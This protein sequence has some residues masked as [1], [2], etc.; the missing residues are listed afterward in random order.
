M[1]LEDGVFYVDDTQLLMGAQK[2][3]DISAFFSIVDFAGQFHA[4]YN[5]DISNAYK[6]DIPLTLT[7]ESS[8]S[9]LAKQ[10][11]H[12]EQPDFIESVMTLTKDISEEDKK[13][14]F[15]VIGKIIENGKVI[16]TKYL[17]KSVYKTR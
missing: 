1:R 9:E 5:A 8:L 4:R 14:F 12:R 7:V 6:V 17:G 10:N 15:K 13:T 2:I 11:P 16:E 3:T